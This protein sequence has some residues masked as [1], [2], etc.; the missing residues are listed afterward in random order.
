MLRHL[1]EAYRNQVNLVL[2]IFGS[3]YQDL[4]LHVRVGLVS[5]GKDQQAFKIGPVSIKS[6]TPRTSLKRLPAGMERSN[7]PR[8]RHLY[9]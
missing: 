1:T 5:L 8:L 7:W 2:C 9:L 6:G 4:K 3:D